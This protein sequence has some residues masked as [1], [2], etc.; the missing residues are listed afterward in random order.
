[1]SRTSL[2]DQ[3][4]STTRATTTT[5]SI[6]H[7]TSANAN[8]AAPR[9]SN[10]RLTCAELGM[11]L[12]MSSITALAVL[13][14]LVPSGVLP[15]MAAAFGVSS[16]TCGSLVGSYAI[17]SA[18][19]GIPLVTL[20]VSANRKR[21]L[22]VLLIGFALSNCIVGGAGCFEVALVGRALGGAC[23]GT[24]W[25][26]ITAYG[27]ECVGAGNRG[28]A[29]TIIMSGI[30]AGMAVGLPAITWLGTLSNYHVEFFALGIILCLVAALCWIFL[31]SIPG[32]ARSRDN[33]VGTMLRNRGV[34]LVVALTFLAVGA[35]YG[36]YT[37]ISNL[38]QEL[39]GLCGACGALAG[40][41]LAGGT[42][43][44]AG[45][46][47]GAPSI[48]QSVAPL[49]IAQAQLFFGIGSI[50]SVVA[51]LAF[52]DRHLWLVTL[53]MFATGAVSMLAFVLVFA[54]GLAPR[55]A[56]D[57]VNLVACVAFVLWGVAFGSLSS[58]FQ[59]ATARQV[60]SGTAVANSLQSASFN[61]SIMLG[62]MSA[63]ALLDSGGTKPIM[64][65]AAV[66]LICG[67]VLSV[68]G[69]KHLA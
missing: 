10:A 1:M 34:L 8:A 53:G 60:T 63:G 33:S 31:P 29:V 20:T 47:C 27:M 30:T 14:E 13:C 49:T 22:C 52:I 23:A 6:A 26:M 44:L 45:G 41:A 54:V 39:A 12:L 50:I 69:K 5:T 56:A 19:C 55:L 40:G 9:T 11:L 42:A 7:A 62:S 57:Q 43:G 59:T 67:F 35:N 61:C 24:L 28:K 16:A 4:P 25:P 3:T 58:I 15:E 46:A 17:T 21:L 48:A 2:N 66:V 36:A 65:A 51:T 18:I 38:V 37:F 68:A 32:E 64:L